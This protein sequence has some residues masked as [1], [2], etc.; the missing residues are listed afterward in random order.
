MKNIEVTASRNY[1][2][3]IGSGILPELGPLLRAQV[4]GSGSAS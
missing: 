4:P 2:V 3:Y 1:T